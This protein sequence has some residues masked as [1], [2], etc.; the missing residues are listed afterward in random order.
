MPSKH[1]VDSVSFEDTA[2]QVETTIS[3]R[4]RGYRS[5]PRSAVTAESKAPARRPRIAR[6]MALA[7]K[8]QGMVDSGEVRDYADLARLGYVSRARLTQIMNLL[9]LAPDIQEAILG[10]DG[11]CTRS[12]LMAE[13]HVRSLAKLVPW[14]DQRRAW[15]A[16]PRP[17]K[18]CLDAIRE[19][20]TPSTKA[21][22]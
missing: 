6:L 17:G 14:E 18:R 16:L 20:Q 11:P 9:L 5:G 1:S 3:L 22:L 21:K 15:T 4:P 19:G 12:T 7:I 10:A 8:F 13:R 2:V